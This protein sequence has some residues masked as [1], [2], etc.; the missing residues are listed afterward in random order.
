MTLQNLSE[1][2]RV[3]L[4]QF[5]LCSEADKQRILDE[6]HKQ[7]AKIQPAVREHTA[8]TPPSV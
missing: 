3:M 4:A 2:E 8:S 6:V 7:A 1:E 5:R